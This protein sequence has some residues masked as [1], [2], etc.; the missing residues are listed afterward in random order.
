MTRGQIE[1]CIRGV[2][3]QRSVAPQVPK[4]KQQSS[5]QELFW[6]LNGHFTAMYPENEENSARFLWL[7]PPLREFRHYSITTKKGSF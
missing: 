5:Q 2:K 7:L 4:L 1:P 6:F 3:I